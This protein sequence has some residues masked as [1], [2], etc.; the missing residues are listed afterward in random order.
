MTDTKKEKGFTA[1][2]NEMLEAIYTTPFTGTEFRIIS[3]II[4]FT[5]GCN[6]DSEELSVGQI[7]EKTKL[8][9][10]MVAKAIRRLISDGI[11][12]SYK[13]STFTSSKRLG[14]NAD[15]DQWIYRNAKKKPRRYSG[16]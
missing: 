13:N 7:A 16:K 3:T 1:I 2:P 6:R 11:V 15:Y 10:D 5:I 8:S 14:I 4:R 12:I 9:Y